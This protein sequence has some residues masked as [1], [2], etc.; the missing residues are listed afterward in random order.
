MAYV[1]VVYVSQYQ[2][3][4]AYANNPNV[5]ITQ[6]QAQGAQVIYL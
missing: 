2:T 5:Q 6:N 1:P 3:Q 4:Y